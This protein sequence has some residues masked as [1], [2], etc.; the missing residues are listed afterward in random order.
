MTEGAFNQEYLALFVNWEGSVFRRVG[1]AAT[2]A[3]KTKPEAGNHYVI[4]CDWGR[5]HDYTVFIV[6][7]ITAGTVVAMERSKQV[8]YAVQ[9]DRLRVLSER[10]QPEQIIAEQNADSLF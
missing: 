1:E 8:D 2:T 7:D 4:G 5:T 3:W 6:V 10:W 9:R